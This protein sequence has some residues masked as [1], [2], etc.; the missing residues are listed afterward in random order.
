MS[1]DSINNA[2]L[3]NMYTAA[4]DALNSADLSKEDSVIH[5]NDQ[6]T[7]ISGHKWVVLGGRSKEFKAANLR[8]RQQFFENITGL[9]GGKDNLPPE[10]LKEFK[11]ED[12]QLDKFNG[13]KSKRPLTA[14]RIIAICEKA[15]ES[16]KA[17]RDAKVAE[18][19][20]HIHEYAA[21]Y[22]AMSKEDQDAYRAKIKEQIM[23]SENPIL[24]VKLLCKSKPNSVNLFM[25]ELIG[26]LSSDLEKADV[27]GRLRQI[28]SMIDDKIPQLK[29]V[30][31][32][33]L[34]S[35][36]SM[37]KSCFELDASG[38]KCV[39]KNCANR[40]PAEKAFLFNKLL[41]GFVRSNLENL[42]A[43]T[44]YFDLDDAIKK[45]QSMEEFAATFDFTA[46]IDKADLENFKKDSKAVY[47]F[48]RVYVDQHKAEYSNQVGG[49]NT[50]LVPS[51][52]KLNERSKYENIVATLDQ[53]IKLVDAGLGK[54]IERAKAKTEVFAKWFKELKNPTFLADLDVL[55]D[56]RLDEYRENVPGGEDATKGTIAREFAFFLKQK[57]S[58]DDRNSRINEKNGESKLPEF[59]LAVTQDGR[60]VADKLVKIT[61][62]GSHE[63]GNNADQFQLANDVFRNIDGLFL[64][65][66]EK[67]AANG[68]TKF[69]DQL[70]DAMNMPGCLQYRIDP[71]LNL[72]TEVEFGV[73][74]NVKAASQKDSVMDGVG[75]KVYELCKANGNKPVKYENAIKAYV[76]SV[77]DG[78]EIKLDDLA[79]KLKKV[80]ENNE[81]FVK[82]DYDKNLQVNIVDTKKFFA[83]PGRRDALEKG[84]VKVSKEF[85]GLEFVKREILDSYG[86]FME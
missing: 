84:T 73:D 76:D 51:L 67:D 70:M 50:Q 61:G 26:R 56:H 29:S 23:E 53:A 81:N 32:D 77:G 47:R 28:T 48:M 57:H 62:V 31:A 74:L 20:N 3:K 60:S 44:A 12:F 65:C 1:L 43:G 17:I 18:L 21:G 52:Q 25:G 72:K 40:P 46:P 75:K 11:M 22:S 69:F 83:D 16:I 71:I 39:L 6:G 19:E 37:L 86:D 36:K 27:D 80:L 66:L 8:T 41:N 30:S 7:V 78:A 5:S 54:D 63:Y 82:N 34:C 55:D 42:A 4:K 85:F 14:R 38:F 59:P 79:G 45:C 33:I 58:V 49:K 9:F 24:D 64:K 2:V 10:V 35:I 15:N 13:V 68:N